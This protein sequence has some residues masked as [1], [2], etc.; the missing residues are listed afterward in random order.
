MDFL[1]ITNQM[2]SLFFIMTVGY[3]MYKVHIIDD[4]ATVR[5]TRL[6]LNI[7]LPSQIITS[8]VSSRGSVT[9]AEVF[10]VFGISVLC[11]L[12]PFAVGILFVFVTR[13]PKS[14]RGT[15]LFMA[16][17]GNVG[18]MGFPVIVTIFGEAA[19]I[20]AVAFNVVFNILV[21]SAGIFFISGGSGGFQLKRMLNVPFMAALL[22]IVLFF[23]GVSFPAPVSSALGYLGN[24]TTP[25]AMLVLGAT[26]A[27]M[28]VRELFGEWRI[29]VFTVF[30]LAL[31][32]L[33]VM[34]VLRALHLT[35]PLIA[36][37]MIVLAATPVATNTTMLAI[38]YDGDTKLA[39]KGI[40]FSTILSV[41]TIPVIAMFC[42]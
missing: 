42:V 31:I 14:E 29:Y 7:S 10:N 22:S 25:V 34:G 33:A 20:Y 11:F 4:A 36:G 38:E 6:V 28:P 3:V 19:L 23:L 16:T 27:S 40:F 21:Y 32:P 2:L 41:A 15:Y 1:T 18:F 24:L 9:N 39:S 35:T 26:I 17:F 12:I 13:T 8:F 30:R 5:Y 37:I